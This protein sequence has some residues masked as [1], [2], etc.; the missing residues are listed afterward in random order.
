MAV[1]SHK[2]QNE[3]KM[4]QLRKCA[5]ILRLDSGRLTLNDGRATLN[6]GR[7]PLNDGRAI[8]LLILIQ[9]L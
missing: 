6:D 5:K 8:S 9:N 3:A 4:I 7:A 2:N 1:D